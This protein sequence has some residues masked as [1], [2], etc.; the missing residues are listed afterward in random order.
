M[1]KLVIVE[2]PT[3]AKKIQ[4][5]LGNG[6][7]V[8]YSQGHIRDLKDN[9]ISIDIEDG[10]KPRYVI[11]S[12]KRQI[13]EGLK[14][15]VEK[16]D[17]VLLASD[18][19][20]EGEAIAWH[21]S[22][23]LE[24]PKDKRERIVFH[25]VTKN[26]ILDAVKHPRD[27]DMNLVAAQQ[28]RRV[29]DRLV[30]FELSPVL[31]KKIQPKLSAGRVQSVA[32]RLIVDRER[33]IEAFKKEQFYKVEA[34][35]IPVSGNAELKGTLDRKFDSPEQAKTFLEQSVG[36]SYCVSD[37]ITK[38]G[39]RSPAAPFTTS[40]LQQEAARKLGMSTSQ[41]MQIAQKLYEEGLITY[42]RTDSLFLSSLAI[43]T[44][45]QFV[46]DNFGDDYSRPCQYKTRS[47]SAQEAHE[48]IRP[49]FIE[50]REIQGTPAE[51]R[52]YDLIWKRTVA[53]QMAEAKVLNTNVVIKSD[54]FEPKYNING[55][56]VLFDGFLRIYAKED[57][58]MEESVLLPD[59][60]AGEVMKENGVSAECKFTTAPARYSQGTLV[61]KLE[62]LGIGRPSTY[63]TIITTLIKGRGYIVE[64][65]KEGQKVKVTN[66]SL[67]DGIVSSSVKTETVGAEKK[68]LLPQDIGI[69]VSDYLV[70]HF[71]NIMDYKFTADVEKEFDSVADG[72][73]AWNAMISSFYSPFHNSVND[74]LEQ[75][76]YSRLEREIGV[77][78]AD[79]KKIIARFGQFGPFVQKGDGPGKICA[80]LGKGQ[81]I[82]SL[83]LDE[84]IK[85]LQMPRN[86]GQIDGVEV[87]VNKG[88]FGPYI[89]FGDK[90]ISLS[91]GK[92]PYKVTLEEVADI[93]R[94]NAEKPTVEILAQ[95]GNIQII[96]GSYGP[97]IKVDGKTNYKL[98]KGTDPAGLTED[99]VK[100]IVSSSEPTSSK[101]RGYRARKK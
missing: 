45:K 44:I 43:N 10:F 57:S 34:R 46:C 97:Y 90:N 37:V 25:E 32:L 69:M 58:D 95:W 70:E 18:E 66:Y 50:N 64:G 42:M 101:K 75:S 76:D 93:I 87:L 39:K 4:G 36:A 94:Q 55:C 91:R 12:D 72:N 41:T 98:P 28:A 54:K 85:L 80:S 86:L 88:R 82:E 84:A 7:T 47:A 77:D 13:V 83:T 24:L 6:Y 92:D 71:P 21:L 67:N 27:I 51:K 16:A 31:W 8:K 65:D 11:P 99:D 62:E 59:I 35:F 61:G 29:L 9:A 40:T 2:S 60:K 100:A 56:K 30:G 52:L 81:I 79:G 78:P 19:D 3:K 63:N 33:E 14:K 23:V 48:A 73:I 96:N 74:T 53:S 20:R 38:E 15:E 17:S 22:E 89:K 26:A 68:K 1:S 49:T 5:Y